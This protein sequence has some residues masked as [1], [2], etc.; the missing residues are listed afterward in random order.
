MKI[1]I[2]KNVFETNSSST[3]CLVLSKE[4]NLEVHEE[5]FQKEY[6]IKPWVEN[7]D[8]KTP[9][10]SPFPPPWAKANKENYELKLESIE[11]KL[12]YFLT[13]Y[14]Q[15]NH[16]CYMDSDNSDTKFMKRLQRLFPN[17]IFALKCDDNSSYILEDGEWFLDTGFD[18]ESE[19]D[20]LMAL[21]DHNFK[22]FMEYGVIYFGSR[23]N[24]NYE[25]FI[26]YGLP[27]QSIIC[28]WSG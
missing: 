15:S 9:L 13:M 22:L 12:T 17:T 2:R 16:G 14:Y 18:D 8:Y 7:Y 11:D 19:C 10:D 26:D 20:H 25:D 21:D 23:D 5:L 24:M 6:I 28:K 4:E 1:N 3:H 27:K